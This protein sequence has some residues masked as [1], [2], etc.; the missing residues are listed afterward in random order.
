MNKPAMDEQSTP[1]AARI[2]AVIPAAGSGRRFGADRPK[3]YLELQPG[4]SVLE[5]SLRAVLSDSRVRGVM[6][7]VAEDDTWWPTLPVTGNDRVWHCRG[8]EERAASVLAALRTLLEQD[9]REDDWVLV[10]DAVR[11]WLSDEALGRLLDHCLS[12]GEAGILA[13][14]VV[15]TVKRVD[16]S[17]RIRE[18][19]PRE[20]IRLAQTPQMALLGVLRDAL[21]AQLEQGLQPTDEAGALEAAGW[22]VTVVEGEA[23]NRKITVPGDLEGR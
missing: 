4:L 8:G 5:A 7:A 11:P 14:S 12:T 19:L 3:Q 1:S 20:R 23:G 2:W 6:V 10:H 9:A 15:D 21:S 16:G 17:G 18:T 22:P 13:L